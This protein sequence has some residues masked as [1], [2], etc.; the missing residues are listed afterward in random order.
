RSYCK[1]L[2]QVGVPF[3]QAYVEATLGRYPLLSR[4]LVELFEA[5]FDLATGSESK[6]DIR[7]GMGDFESQLRRLAGDDETTMATLRQAIEARTGSR[8]R[9]VE[10]TRAALLG[11]MD[12]VSSLDDDRILRSFIGVIDATL[13]TSYYIQREGGL[14]K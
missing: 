8:E 11:L 7:R 13:R 5:R 4:L 2:L 9:Q 14:R 10:A 3:S 6:A 1:Y 12:R